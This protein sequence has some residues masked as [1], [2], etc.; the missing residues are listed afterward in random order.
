[1]HYGPMGSVLVDGDPA[2][3]DLLQATTEL[4]TTTTSYDNVSADNTSV[5]YNQSDEFDIVDAI[6]RYVTPV[7]YVLGIPGNILAYC[8]WTRRRMRLSSGCYL[9]A[10][11]L[12]EC[13]FLVMQVSQKAICVRFLRN[14]STNIFSFFGRS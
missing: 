4:M 1:M 13:V 2:W 9:A 11:A 8:V 12:D 14:F 5:V 10:L 6:D 7:W 3:A